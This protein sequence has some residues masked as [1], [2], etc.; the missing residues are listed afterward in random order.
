MRKE[1]CDFTLFSDILVIVICITIILILM[2]K[3][4]AQDIVDLTSKNSKLIIGSLEYRNNEVRRRFNG[5]VIWDK[6]ITGRNL[7]SKDAV[8]IGPKSSAVLKF[9]DG[10][11][12]TLNEKSLAI[13]DLAAKKNRSPEIKLYSGS[14]L[15][16]TTAK[17]MAIKTSSGDLVIDN[18]SSGKVRV[19]SKNDIYFNVREGK[20]IIHSKAGDEQKLI[21]GQ[22][23]KIDSHSNHI[24]NISYQ[25]IELV[26]PAEQ[27]YFY[28]SSGKESI[29]FKWQSKKT[30]Q[31][32]KFI[33]EVSSDPQF[34]KISHRYHVK[35]NE[36]NLNLDA[37]IYYWRIV[38]DLSDIVEQ[39]EE[40]QFTIF[41]D[42]AP[43]IYY[44]LAEV[45]IDKNEMI[46][47]AW[48]GS[49]HASSYIVQISAAEKLD[50][51]LVELNSVHAN[52]TIDNIFKVGRYCARVRNDDDHHYSPW[53][54]NNCF[55]IIDSPLLEAPKVFQPRRELV[56]PKK[57][58]KKPMGFIFWQLIGSIAYA[59]A[60][61]QSAIVLRWEPIA[62]AR[63]YIVEIAE[64]SFFKKLIIKEKV[65][66]TFYQWPVIARKNYY[67]RVRGVDSK[68]Q[69]GI[70]S[71]PNLIRTD[72]IATPE[73]LSPENNKQYLS[74]GK[75]PKINLR[76]KGSDLLRAYKLQ[77]ASDTE[78]KHLIINEI[79]DIT[80]YNFIPAKLGLYY[81]KV[82]GIALDGKDTQASES[83]EI[84]VMPKPP[85]IIA[86]KTNQTIICNDENQK[87]NIEWIAKNINDYEIEI[88][89]DEIFKN[90]LQHSISAN[91]IISFAPNGYGKYYARV[92]GKKPR[93]D[94][95]KTTVVVFQPKPPELLV[96]S[97][98]YRYELN[99][100]NQSVEFSWESVAKAT[101]YEISVFKILPNK[102]ALICKQQVP[103]PTAQCEKFSEG[104]YDWSVRTIANDNI[105]NPSATRRFYLQTSKPITEKQ[106]TAEDSLDISNDNIQLNSLANEEKIKLFIS[107]KFG[108][109]TNFGEV[110]T[111]IVGGEINYQLSYLQNRLSAD[112]GISYLRDTIN[113]K[114]QDNQ[115][116]IK[117]QIQ[118]IP[119]EFALNY[120]IYNVKEIDILTGIGISIFTNQV[121]LRA[122][123]QPKIFKTSLAFG[124]YGVITGETKFGK[125]NI[126]LKMSYVMSNHIKNELNEISYTGLILCLGYRI[127]VW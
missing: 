63:A 109:I 114:T 37:G 103:T 112:L 33:F 91:H 123:N 98:E 28:T 118:T 18:K 24:G 11:Q 111:P 122:S 44:P 82:I 56:P 51:V 58:I 83:R 113:K 71:A 60:S 42:V 50:K 15:G 97:I 105:S 68:G 9:N 10:A 59:Q 52:I 5:S 104:V 8:Y 61:T 16:K 12:I 36:Y 100:E 90:I 14:A 124:G 31:V 80:E 40:R 86:P 64:D 23:S 78:F 92:K 46:T 115:L 120:L 127:G 125:G 20:G 88:A 49:R 79:L 21:A 45:A 66:S 32:K 34:E 121:E 69:E 13:I 2:Q 93:S 1:A 35:E 7:Y 25:T 75:A 39:S 30:P 26:E 76:W 4:F 67:W 72:Y 41:H 84:L 117:A 17:S 6:L 54:N 29:T 119:I 87:I 110:L 57:E 108:V 94:W 85:E 99:S 43:I 27:K 89:N 102:A 73:I 53:S 70:P 95:S 55:R 106:Y 65:Q 116:E 19:D 81:W 74:R 126:F 47:I 62:K 22:Y 38:N 96:P 101:G 3:V 48:A 107:L 77:I